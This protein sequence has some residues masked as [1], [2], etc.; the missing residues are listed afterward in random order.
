M[1]PAPP[2]GAA[3]ATAGAGGLIVIQG[4]EREEVA[5]FLPCARLVE[6]NRGPR[7]VA[8]PHVGEPQRRGTALGRGQGDN[9]GRVLTPALRGG[10]L[11]ASRGV[12]THGEAEAKQKSAEGVRELEAEPAAAAAGQPLGTAPSVQ[13]RRGAALAQ[14]QVDV[15]PRYVLDMRSHQ[16]LQGRQA[17]GLHDPPAQSKASEEAS[18]TSRVSGAARAPPTALE[19]GTR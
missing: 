15:L 4:F 17:R 2:A 7:A 10:L 12:H 3:A 5:I 9:G 11:H 13:G 1:A 16:C 19:G 18:T 8:E 14:D 6:A